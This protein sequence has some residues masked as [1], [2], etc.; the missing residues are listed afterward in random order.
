MSPLATL[1]RALDRV[2]VAS[3]QQTVL[4]VALLVAGVGVV[5]L[6]RAAGG[7]PGTFTTVVLVILG[8]VA[9][10]VADSS[11]PLFFVLALGWLWAA[12]VP[13]VW[14]GWTLGAA[15]LL[16]VV[17]VTSTLCGYGPPALQLPTRLLL[18]WASRAMVMLA[19]A[20]LVWV[21]AGVLTTLE[22]PPNRALVVAAL[23]LVGGWVGVLLSRLL[24]RE[25]A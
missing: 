24:S 4:R 19:S 22:L 16:T 9:A 14:S 6:V 25:A 13:D 3:R 12:E 21:A 7:S 10:T 17:H 11:A 20:A 23:A 15:A 18:V 1:G 2:V 5:V 8:L